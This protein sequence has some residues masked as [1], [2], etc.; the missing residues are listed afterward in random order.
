MVIPIDFQLLRLVLYKVLQKPVSHAS[1]ESKGNEAIREVE[2]LVLFL[3]VKCDSFKSCR[4][5][6]PELIVLQIL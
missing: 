2:K 1:R 5:F 3:F 4:D 6:E